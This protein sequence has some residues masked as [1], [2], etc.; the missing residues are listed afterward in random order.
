MGKRGGWDGR[1]AN[2]RSQMKI[3]EEEKT[4]LKGGG[5][6]FSEFV[7][8]LPQRVCAPYDTYITFRIFDRSINTIPRSK[9][10]YSKDSFTYVSY[11]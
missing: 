11:V 3:R 9:L 6:R 4:K 7:C 1:A 2:Q 8:F 5:E 10:Q